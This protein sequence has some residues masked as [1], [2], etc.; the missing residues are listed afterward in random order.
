MEAA[1]IPERAC[2]VALFSSG[3]MAAVL[4]SHPVSTRAAS[5]TAV[6]RRLTRKLGVVVFMAASLPGGA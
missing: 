5:A 1:Q 3:A 6:V 2:G 4:V